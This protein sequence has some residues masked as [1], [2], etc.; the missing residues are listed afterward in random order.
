MLLATLEAM[1]GLIA[2]GLLGHVTGI[3]DVAAGGG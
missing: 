1:P 2:V 3:T